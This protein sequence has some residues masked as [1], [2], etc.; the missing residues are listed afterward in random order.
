MKAI[1]FVQWGGAI[2][3]FTVVVYLLANGIAILYFK[4]KATMDDLVKLAG[5]LLLFIGPEVLAGFFGNV[6]KRRQEN[7]KKQ[8]PEPD[9]G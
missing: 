2:L 3:V 5:I 9:S 8:D 7:G 6:I 1:K 4:V